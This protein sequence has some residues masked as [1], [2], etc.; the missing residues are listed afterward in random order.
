MTWLRILTKLLLRRLAKFSTYIQFER[1]P[2]V[3]AL[4]VLGLNS[5]S[6]DTPLIQKVEMLVRYED[7]DIHSLRSSPLLIIYRYT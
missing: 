2:L 3:G 1:A 4:F 5:Y 6:F 7:K